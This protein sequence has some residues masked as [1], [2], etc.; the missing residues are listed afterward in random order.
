MGAA[1]CVV[2]VVCVL[3]NVLLCIDYQRDTVIKES[4]LYHLTDTL[5]NRK[6]D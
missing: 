6:Y 4:S 3:V 1:V 5:H 2:C